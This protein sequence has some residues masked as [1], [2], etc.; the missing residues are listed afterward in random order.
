MQSERTSL[1]PPRVPDAA[2]VRIGHAGERCVER[3][4]L[5]EFDRRDAHCGDGLR[6][7]TIR[8]QFGEGA[9]QQDCGGQ[10]R[11]FEPES[12]QAVAGR[13]VVAAGAAMAGGGRRWRQ[14]KAG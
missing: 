8:R 10:P 7:A 9:A 14:T 11:R 1:R 6:G 13:V 2:T 12:F 5:R 4:D 3:F